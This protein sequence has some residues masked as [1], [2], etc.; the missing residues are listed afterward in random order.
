MMKLDSSE[1]REINY[2]ELTASSTW[3]HLCYVY[4]IVLEYGRDEL[5]KLGI[6]LF[7]LSCKRKE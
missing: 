5:S 3:D 6:F 1:N 2:R 7:K 4:A